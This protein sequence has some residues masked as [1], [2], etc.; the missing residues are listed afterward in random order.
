[1]ADGKKRNPKVVAFI[2]DKDELPKPAAV[3]VDRY[4]IHADP[5]PDGSLVLKVIDTER[6]EDPVTASLTVNAGT[7]IVLH[8]DGYGQ[9]VK[10]GHQPTPK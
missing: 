2:G 3:D 6:P 4:E 1:M 9:T 10:F 8:G 5:G 7:H